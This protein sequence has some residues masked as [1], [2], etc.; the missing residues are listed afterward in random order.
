[1][2][3]IVSFIL[4]LLCF[5]FLCS[6]TLAQENQGKRDVI[7]YY[8]IQN[9][10][11]LA[12]KNN[13]NL[14]K[15][16]EEIAN[17]IK[18]CYSKRFNVIEIRPAIKTK[19]LLDYKSMLNTPG[20]TIPVIVQ[21]QLKGLAPNAANIPSINISYKELFGDK[22]NQFFRVY[23]Y[24]TLTY[25]STPQYS[26]LTGKFYVEDDRRLVKNGVKACINTRCTFNPPNRY[27]NPEEYNFYVGIF[28][29]DK[30]TL[31]SLPPINHP[32]P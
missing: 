14:Q 5:S 18:K 21:I 29:G 6:K 26:S 12:Q 22:Y 19:Y 32:I 7:L 15:G 27:T 24:G 13:G 16:E 4:A 25:H 8:D 17:F 1:M 28:V 10:I 11:I 20:N 9:E 23:D 2:H 30:S 3:K 31:S